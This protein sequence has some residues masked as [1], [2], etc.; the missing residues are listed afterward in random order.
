MSTWLPTVPVVADVLVMVG[1]GAAVELTETLSNV[2]VARDEE[3]PLAT[4]RP[5]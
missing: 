5:M 4:A 1:P 2:A 3:F